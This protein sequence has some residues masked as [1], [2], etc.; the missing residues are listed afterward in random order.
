MDAM[1]QCM[2]WMRSLGWVGMVLGVSL[3]AGLVVLIVFLIRR[4][5]NG[6]T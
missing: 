4:S 6:R 5:W 2:E 3:L 1:R